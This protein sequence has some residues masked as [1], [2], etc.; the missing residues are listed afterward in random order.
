MS[1]SI[2]A[3]LFN[4]AVM[5]FDWVGA[6]EN[7]T[8]FLHGTGQISI[9]VNTSTDGTAELVRA[10]IA[11]NRGTI[12]NTRVDVVETA[13]PYTDPTFDGQIKAAALAKCT[14]PFAI[15]LDCDERVYPHHFKQWLALARELEMSPVDG[16]LIPVV[17]LLGDEH[18]YKHPIGTKFYLHKNR[19]EITRGV[20]AQ[21]RQEDG[22]IDTSI[23]DSTEP[24]IRDTGQLISSARLIH[25][26]YPPFMV[27][28]QLENMETPM[29]LHLGW[30]DT[31]QRLRQSA[32]WKDV[33]TARR[34]GKDPEPETTLST[35]DAIPRFRHNLPS[36][37][38]IP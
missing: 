5:R 13:I 33:W 11:A 15:L 31:Q 19:P 14:E 16:I 36:W 9:A 26:A 22:S 12:G 38:G 10:W 37:R 29:V 28:G 17:D 2:Y 25:P 6:L 7:W 3:S 18:H 32:F 4:V 21:A 34:G 23:S 24:I 30:L 20:I 27:M 8:Q 1:L 35:L